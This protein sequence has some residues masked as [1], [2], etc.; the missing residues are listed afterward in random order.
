MLVLWRRGERC[1]RFILFS[2]SGFT[3]AMVARANEDGVVM[4]CM[5]TRCG[6]GRRGY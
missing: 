1:D 4:R 6:E 5:G 3:D 2:R